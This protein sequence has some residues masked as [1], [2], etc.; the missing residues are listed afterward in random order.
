MINVLVHYQMSTQECQNM[1]PGLMKC[2]KN[3]QFWKLFQKKSQVNFYL[4][5]LTKWSFSS[6]VAYF[7]QWFCFLYLSVCALGNKDLMKRYHMKSYNSVFS[8]YLRNHKYFTGQ[9]CTLFQPP[10][11]AAWLRIKKPHLCSKCALFKISWRML[12][13]LPQ[14]SPFTSSLPYLRA[15]QWGTVWPCT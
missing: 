11:Y 13:V 15:F 10:Q 12:R 14:P 9:N 2:W 4:V 7:L 5:S 3:G 6:G 1:F 8:T